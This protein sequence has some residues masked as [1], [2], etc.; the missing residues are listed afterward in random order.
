MGCIFHA[1]LRGSACCS[2]FSCGVS[3]STG[4]EGICAQLVELPMGCVGGLSQHAP[5]ELLPLFHP[6]P[7]PVG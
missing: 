6:T 3:A 7:T 4:L 1:W 5:E 2:G